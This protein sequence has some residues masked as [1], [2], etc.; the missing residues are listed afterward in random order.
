M[1]YTREEFVKEYGAKIARAVRGTGILAGTL[2][3]QAIIESQGKIGGHHRV[4]GSKL[5]RNSNNYF[6]IKCHGWSGKTYNIDTGEQNPDGSTYVDKKA[7]FRAYDS[8][9]DSL[10]DYV[11]LLKENPRY[12]KAGV[13]EADTV[14][15]QAQALKDAGYATSNKYA[16][17]VYNV[18]KPLAPLVE[19]YAKKKT[20]WKAIA[21]IGLGV[22]IITTATIVLIKSRK[23]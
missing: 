1:S 7:C 4:G 15:Q 16:S 6:G 18:Y 12:A 14:K 8:V 3:A 17:T 19:E 22:A 10:K 5:A 11:K 9:E 23:K 21:L 2:I 20:N 13:F